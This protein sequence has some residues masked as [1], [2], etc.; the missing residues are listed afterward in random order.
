VV[1]DPAIGQE[2]WSES[3]LETLWQGNGLRV[4]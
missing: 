2:I 4:R 3:K 1:A